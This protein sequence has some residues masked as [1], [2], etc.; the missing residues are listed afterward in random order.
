MRISYREARLSRQNI[1]H[2]KFRHNREHNP[3]VTL[4]CEAKLK[5]RDTSYKVRDTIAG[6]ELRLSLIQHQHR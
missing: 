2:S 6:L 5:T 4:E 3:L 1:V